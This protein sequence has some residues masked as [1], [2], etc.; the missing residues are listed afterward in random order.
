MLIGLLTLPLNAWAVHS[1]SV[2]Y[3]ESNLGGGLWKYDYKIMND[4]DPFADAGYNIYDLFLSFESPLILTNIL[5]PGGWD[6]ISDASSFIDWFSTNPGEP[7]S[8]TD[9]PPAASLSGFSFVS[10]TRLASFPFDILLSNPDDPM[11]PVSVSGTTTST[12]PLPS[13]IYLLITGIIGVISLR[14]RLK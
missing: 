14:G 9:I 7:P 10:N 3:S 6:Q 1:S 11:N 8:G 12:V 4:S 5:S 2:L 13:T